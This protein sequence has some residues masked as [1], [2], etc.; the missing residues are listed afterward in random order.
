MQYINI[1]FILYR[2]LELNVYTIRLIEHGWYIVE[3][4]QVIDLPRTVEEYKNSGIKSN[5]NNL[6]L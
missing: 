6:G 3:K 1:P 5:V 4:P 2:G